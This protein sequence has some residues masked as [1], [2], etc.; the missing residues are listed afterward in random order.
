MPADLH[1]ITERSKDNTLPH[2]PM[3]AEWYQHIRLG[4]GQTLTPAHTAAYQSMH[5]ALMSCFNA[6]RAN[7]DEANWDIAVQS[8]C[9]LF[10]ARFTG[11]NSKR[12]RPLH[13]PKRLPFEDNRWRV[14]WK[15]TKN[16]SAGPWLLDPLHDLAVAL[17]ELLQVGDLSD[18]LE[19]D[20]KVPEAPSPPSH[21]ARKKKKKAAGNLKKSTDQRMTVSYNLGPSNRGTS[22]EDY[23]A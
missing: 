12:F 22:S 16:D 1:F 2:S 17:I 8:K 7:Q 5:P 23:Y 11:E 21:L 10:Y 14:G 15:H 20:L 13:M 3:S 4:Q 6:W 9:Y 19:I 18:I